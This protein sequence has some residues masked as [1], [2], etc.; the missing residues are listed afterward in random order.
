MLS[1]M[2]GSL[3]EALCDRLLDYEENVRKGV[4]AA[5]CDVACHSP[6]AITTGTIKV[7]AERVRDKSVSFSAL[8][9]MFQ[10]SLIYFD[11]YDLLSKYESA[12]GCEVLYHGKVGRHL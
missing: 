5:L 8:I 6:D 10:I 12:A 3:A 2:V 4:V 9:F 1:L 11:L 7:V